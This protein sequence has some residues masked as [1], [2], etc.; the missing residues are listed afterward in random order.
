MERM[1]AS[2]PTAEAEGVADL[3]PAPRPHEK[4]SRCDPPRLALDT[5]ANRLQ[6][7]RGLVTEG[8]GHALHTVGAA[9]AATIADD[10]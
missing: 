2:G 7:Q 4:R 5:C 8:G 3:E 1:S 9:R 10:P 6:L